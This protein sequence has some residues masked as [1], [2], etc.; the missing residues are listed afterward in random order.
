MAKY[1]R[2]LMISGLGKASRASDSQR[3][4]VI[5]EMLL[6]RARAAFAGMYLE[7]AFIEKFR[8]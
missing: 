6:Y 1:F 3:Q 7:G 8:T 2:P 4:S 5:A